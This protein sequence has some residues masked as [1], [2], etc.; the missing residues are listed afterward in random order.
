V[1]SI[2]SMGEM[3]C[4]LSA[5]GGWEEGRQ[6]SSA[7]VVRGRRRQPRTATLDSLRGPWAGVYARG[8]YRCEAAKQEGE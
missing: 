4:I 6:E 5:M 8:A 7:V 3:R 2:D 1:E